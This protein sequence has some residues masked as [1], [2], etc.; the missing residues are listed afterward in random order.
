MNFES[1]LPLLNLSVKT[2]EEAL[3]IP[4][5]HKI[6]PIL[7]LIELLFYKT[8]NWEKCDDCEEFKLLRDKLLAATTSALNSRTLPTGANSKN[9]N[10]LRKPI[11][12]IVLH[13]LA[14]DS[15]RYEKSSKVEIISY[16]NA[17]Q[18]L[19]L[20]AYYRGNPNANYKNEL[21][22]GDLNMNRFFE[23]FDSSAF[24]NSDDYQEFELLI[25]IP[26][27]I[28]YHYFVFS[29]GS[30]IQLSGH[31]ELLWH[32][33]G[34]NSDG[35]GV[36]LVGNFNEVQPTIVQINATRE[37]LTNLNDQ[38]PNDLQMV[39]HKEILR[40]DGKPNKTTCPGETFGD[41]KTDI[42]P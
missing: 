33:N 28:Q 11:S 25:G 2:I 39:G 15:S 21:N 41:W 32:S 27:F 40:P 7:Q 18:L 36:C 23:H 16:V 9:D 35:V 38:Y 24:V 22:H 29:D 26:N 14:G 30:V 3:K 10:D 12:K 42:L 1:Q 8:E 13:H 4:N 6:S 17:L 19:R 31:K 34:G 5:W 20:T 37:L